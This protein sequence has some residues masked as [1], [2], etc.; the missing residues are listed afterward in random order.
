M[1]VAA[2][3]SVVSAV[4][5]RPGRLRAAVRGEARAA[6][7]AARRGDDHVV[8]PVPGAAGAQTVYPRPL[9]SPLPVWVAVGGTPARSFAP[10]RSASRWRSRSSVGAPARFA[11]LSTLYRD[12][13][14]RAGHDPARSSWASTRS[15]TSPTPPS[16]RQTSST[17]GLRRS[18]TQL[19]RERG[20]VPTN[21]RR[22]S[23][24][25]A[26]RAGRCSSGARRRSSSRSSTS[27]SCSATRASSAQM[28]VGVNPTTGSMH[29]IELFG[30]RVAP[31]VRTA[32]WNGASA[33]SEQRADGQP[34]RSLAWTRGA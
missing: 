13:A 34:R 16:V 10:A 2:R 29:A 7:R 8:G 9:Q 33:P 15:V 6:A 5:V 4:R 20:W 19:G 30:T 14:E 1:A 22:S 32:L 21:P 12:A 3:S 31:E 27:T 11:R 28:D 26:V 25:C 17:R 18:M 24:G 23:S